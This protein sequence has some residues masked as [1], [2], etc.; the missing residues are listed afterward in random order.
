MQTTSLLEPS[1]LDTSQ[2]LCV[3]FTSKLGLSTLD[4]GR[5]TGEL[6][7]WLRAASRSDTKLTPPTSLLDEAWHLFI[8]D[9][10][11]YVSFC[12]AEFGGYLHHEPE[13]Q[14]CHT[15]PDMGDCSAD[16]PH[17]NSVRMADE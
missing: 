4:A 13:M 1:N 6:L 15:D 10:R 17:C 5:L 12:M 8:L 7:E 11:R 2:R 14:D 3:R 16:A 9:T